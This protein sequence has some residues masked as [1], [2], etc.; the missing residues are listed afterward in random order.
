MKI[1]KSA[2]TNLEILFKKINTSDKSNTSLH[3]GETNYIH[4]KKEKIIYGII[5]IMYCYNTRTYLDKI[6][7]GKVR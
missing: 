2:K 4:P 1:L 7:S 5:C 6:Y 3:L